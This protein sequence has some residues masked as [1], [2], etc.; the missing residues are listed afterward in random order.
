MNIVECP[1][2]RRLLFFMRRD[3][4]EKAIPHR[5]K[6]TELV[7]HT[8]IEEFNILKADLAVSIQLLPMPQIISYLSECARQNLIYV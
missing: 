4:P 1:E 2:F 6:L 3:I 5:T 8:W 7:T